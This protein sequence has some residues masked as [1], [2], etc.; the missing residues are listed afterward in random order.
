MSKK[1]SLMSDKTFNLF[2]TSACIGLAAVSIFLTWQNR[3]LKD[4]LAELRLPQI[5]PEALQQGD[6][7][8]P[9]TLLD[10]VGNRITI[11]FGA[12]EGK[13]LLLI[14]S[15]DCPACVMTLPIWSEMLEEPPASARV[16][17]LRLG[18]AQ[19]DDPA[20]PCTVYAPDEAGSGLAGK[21]PFVPATL[22]L[23]DRGVVEQVWYGVLQ[24]DDQEALLE[25]INR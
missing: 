4:E 7:M 14:F 10:N 13:T 5:P 16:I 3:N 15:P 23:D 22:L 1:K 20:L 17:G 2:I 6:R 24:D 8:E 19:E 12:R 25:S 11:G 18:E 9:L 21:I